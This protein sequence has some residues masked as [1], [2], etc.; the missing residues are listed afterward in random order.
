MSEA[1]KKQRLEYK[2]KRKNKIILQL[3]AL[4]LVTIIMFGAFFVY[5]RMN[6][7]YYIHYTE[8][9]EVDYKVY[10]KENDFFEEE[11]LGAENAYIASLIKNVVADFGYSLNMD[12]TNVGFDY[13]YGIEAQLVINDNDSGEALFNPIYEIQPVKFG[14]VDRGQTLVIEDQV[15]IDYVKYNDLA[16][17]FIEVYQL[18]SV[19][20]TLAVRMKVDVISRCAEFEKNNQNS[21]Y[22][23]LNI[24]LTNDTLNIEMSSSIPEEE[25]KVL[26]CSGA[27]D[28]KIFLGIGAVAAVIDAVLLGIFLVFI[29]VTRNDDINYTNKVKR[30]VSAYRSYIQQLEGDFDDS[31]Y[32]VLYIKSFNEMLGIRDT[33]QSPILMSENEDKTC[34]RFIITTNTKIIYVFEIKVDNYDELYGIEKA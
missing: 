1:E 17:R 14:T 12:T 3:I 29:H 23:S 7:T 11:W 18:K 20:S 19:T 32:Q 22:V 25:S 24:P 6:Q 2:L 34:T 8:T 26:A 13:S 31:N 9:G 21:Y 10:L 28:Q 27:I 30:L 5:H 33:I 15:E 4:S 16:N